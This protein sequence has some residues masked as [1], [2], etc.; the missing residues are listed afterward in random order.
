MEQMNE[1]KVAI[2]EDQLQ[3]REMLAALV[4][5]SEGFRCVAAYEQS[6]DAIK[7]IP[8][9]GVDV[10]L[11]DIHM[12]GQLSGID[13]VQAIKQHCPGLPFV[14]CTSLEDTE[15]IFRA[16]QAGAVGYIT[17]STP[18]DK[19]L[20]ALTDACNGGAPMNSQ[21]ARK[22]INHFFAGQKTN[23]NAELD[24][25]SAREQE[26]LSF[27]SKGYRYKEIAAKLFVSIETV[28]KHIHNIYEKLQ[29]SSRTDAI[30]KVYPNKQNE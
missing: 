16:L 18:S 3:T 9:L 22:V 28:R 27:L 24:K 10:V 1:I 21:I 8:L 5:G 7:N 29:V 23:T 19:I 15:S 11:M 17:K 13:C 25:L 30:N 26:I 2:V 12:P 6:N 14:M 20:E 4:G